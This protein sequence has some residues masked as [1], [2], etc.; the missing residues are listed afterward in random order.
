M[1]ERLALVLALVLASGC[2][3]CEETYS[4]IVK[5][6]VGIPLP[7]LITMGVAAAL[8]L[9]I[10]DAL[11]H[12][13]R[14]PRGGLLAVAAA[15]VL[16]ISTLP[17]WREPLLALAAWLASAAALVFLCLRN[18]EPD[19]NR[20]SWT[21]SLAG[22]LYVSQS[23]RIMAGLLVTLLVSVTFVGSVLTAVSV[24]MAGQECH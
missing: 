4:P 7:T 20:Q 17:V 11:G 6:L 5:L 19:P 1:A 24:F 10:G 15:C 12:T 2:Q 8:M 9:G 22:E 16:P 23:D 18:Q 3:P 14:L 21:H 13:K